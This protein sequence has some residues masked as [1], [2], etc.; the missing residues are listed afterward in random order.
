MFDNLVRTVVA[1]C[2][3]GIIEELISSGAAGELGASSV[4]GLEGETVQGLLEALKHY[5]DEC[6]RALASVEKGDSGAKRIG[7]APITGL[8]GTD[9]Q[10]VLMALKRETEMAVAGKDGVSATH[11]WSGTRLTMTSA[12]G[13]SSADLKG[14]KGDPGDKGDT[15]ATVLWI[16]EALKELDYYDGE[17]SG[18]YG[19]LTKEAV[20]QFQRDNDLSADGVAGA[21]TIAKLT[22]KISKDSGSGDATYN[23][24]IYNIN[25]FSN[26]FNILSCF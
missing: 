11:F 8:D 23:S 2:V 21:K 9:V 12:S 3:N 22:E 14:D 13:T 18:S 7:V 6:I 10:T 25:W 4:E 15:G 24:K 16:Q 1:Q 17:L 19:K 26:N 20:R 5:C